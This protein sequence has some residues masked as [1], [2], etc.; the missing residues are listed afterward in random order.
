MVAALHHLVHPDGSLHLLNDAAE[1]IA[2]PAAS[3]TALARVVLG[4]LAEKHDG[5]WGLPDTGYFGTRENAGRATLL[6]D[7]GE[8]GPSHQPGHAHCDLLSFELDQAGRRVVVDSGVHGYEGDP[9][10][11]LVRSTRAHNTVMIAGREQSEVW[12]TFRM[13]RRARVIRGSARSE[14]GEYI[15]TGAYRPYHDRGASHERELR[16]GAGRLIVTDRVDG[17]MGAPLE[18][19]LHLH[20]D[21]TAER[22]GDRVVARAGA[23]S[24]TIEPF[25]IDGLSLHRGEREPVQGWY[26][27]RFGVA[28]ANA[29]LVMRVDRNAGQP[30][31]YRIDITSRPA[32]HT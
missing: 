4:D 20:P 12:A 29:V 24:V 22:S 11:E 28:I 13:A 15:F 3:L 31:G 14:Q 1:G 2:T 26:C 21:F 6:V 25:G 9:Y 18:S 30:F 16:Y 5:P 7:C 23:M 27:P 10:R 8:P 32:D 19:F 17:A